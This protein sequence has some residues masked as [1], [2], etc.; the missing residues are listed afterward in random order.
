MIF[1]AVQAIFHLYTQ[2][3]HFYLIHSLIHSTLR[4]MVTS[5]IPDRERTLDFQLLGSLPCFP[6]VAST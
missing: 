4:I 3:V 2:G 6:S 1:I 5:L